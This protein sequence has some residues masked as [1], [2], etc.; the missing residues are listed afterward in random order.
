M[1]TLKFIL[2]FSLITIFITTILIYFFYLNY[3][4]EK[5]ITNIEQEN[6]ISFEF[7]KKAE[8]SFL[9]KIKLNFNGNVKDNLKKFYSENIIFSF[10]QPYMFVPI[11]F[12]VNS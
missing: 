6:N 10:D 9:P 7:V 11:N 5:I 4:L 12:N 3:N 8:W 1:K 2:S